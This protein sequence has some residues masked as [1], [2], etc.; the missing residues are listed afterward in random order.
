MVKCIIMIKQINKVVYYLTIFGIIILVFFIRTKMLLDN[1][2]FWFDESALGYNVLTLN[3]KELFG[4]LHLQQVAPPLFLVVSK[5]ISNIFGVSD[6]TLRLFPFIIGN[7]S[8]IMF[9]FVLQK[10]LKNKIAI[11]FGFIAFCFNL[12]IL[13]YTVEFKPY[14]CEVFSMCIILYSFYK[15]NWN[16][17]YKNL[18]FNGF[19]LALLPWFSFISVILL[20]VIYVI[21]FSKQNFKKW[22]TFIFPS[23]L[24]FLLFIFYYLKIN[25]FYKS[26][27][28]DCWEKAFLTTGNFFMFVKELFL[29]TMNIK[30][31]ILSAAFFFAGFVICWFKHRKIAVFSTLI[32]CIFIMLSFLKQYIFY[33]RFLL[34]LIPLMILISIMPLEFI[35][36]KRKVFS[37]IIIFFSL[38]LFIFP[39][40]KIAHISFTHK[41]SK[42]SCAREFMQYLIN[43]KK[44]TDYIFVDNLSA[45]EFLYYS[46][47]YKFANKVIINIDNKDNRI[48]YSISKYTFFNNNYNTWIYAPYSKINKNN[49]VYTH[50]KKCNCNI[51]EIL[52]VTG[53][54]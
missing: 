14:I 49:L 9:Y 42:N 31:F 26:F 35:S 37:G 43:N 39:S 54:K 51:G 52:Y 4:I 53:K 7:L 18:L 6:I 1:P 48:L 44:D 8:L 24:S 12:Q 40:I 23:L 21:N 29:Y 28:L 46:C 5:F 19:C 41:F 2:S 15:F 20:T 47:Y 33:E 36:F 11:L 50:Y 27:M 10:Y 30:L 25:N 38:F 13:N 32:F 45:N 3:Y 17:S 34:F 16:N 22:L